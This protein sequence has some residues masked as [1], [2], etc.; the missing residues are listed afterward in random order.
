MNWRSTFH[1]LSVIVFLSLIYYL[2]YQTDRVQFIQMFAI[3]SVAFLILAYWWYDKLINVRW[4]WIIAI[5]ARVL[6][7][8]SAPN[9]SDDYFRFVWDG[10]LAV[11]GVNP[12]AFLPGDVTDLGHLQSIYDGLNSKEYYS[13]YPPVM[14]FIF[15]LSSLIA[16]DNLYLNIVMLKLFVCIGDIGVIYFAIKILRR[17]ERNIKPVILYALNPLVMIETV[18]NLHFE[19]VMM[20][21]TLWGIYLLMKWRGSFKALLGVGFVFSLGILTKI[22]S[23]LFLPVLLRKIGFKN[24]LTLGLVTVVCTAI[25]FVPFIDEQAI[26][27][28]S[29]SLD[30]YFR[31]FEFNASIYFVANTIYEKIVGWQEIKYVGPALAI[32]NVVLILFL[33]IRKKITSWET[34]FTTVLAIL[35]IHLLLSTT[36]HP[37]YLINL[38]VAS[39]FTRYRFVVFW[40][41]SIVLSYYF[42]KNYHLP[43]GILWFEYLIF[44]GVLIWEWVNL[45]KQT[46]NIKKI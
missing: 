38:I 10:Y 42:Y 5:A 26:G 21:F 4:I 13:V 12:F 41:W 17:L 18:G 14:Q 3:Y 35:T 20:S 32:L 7:L 16:G 8:F 34:Y 37:W 23:V 15:W 44:I 43:I 25:A 22:V 39:M 6:L 45:K 2:G 29:Q 46:P 28:F 36:V 31:K 11:S 24:T 40:S 27:N 9:F 30:L 33:V 1:Y 19:G